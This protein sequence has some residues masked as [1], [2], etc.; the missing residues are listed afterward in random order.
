[1]ATIMLNH[2]LS[3]HLATNQSIPSSI[4]YISSTLET[5]RLIARTELEEGTNGPTLHRWQLRLISLLAASNPSSIR[6]A[7]F[8]LL[9]HTFTSSSTLFLAASKQTLTSAQQVLSTPISKL[10]PTLYLAAVETTKLIVAKSTWYPEWAR[11]NVGAQAVQ[12]FVSSL[13]QAVNESTSLQIKLASLST[14]C[15]L[16]PLFPTALRPLSPSLHAL[17]LSLLCDVT[18]PPSLQDSASNL[19]VSL[20]L[21]APK[22]KEGLREAWKTGVEALVASCDELVSIVT[23]GIFSED[24]L[25][26]HTLSPLALPPLEGDGQSPFPALARLETLSLVLLKALRTPSTEKAGEVSIPVGALVELGVRMVGFNR[27]SPTKERVDPTVHTLTMSLVPKIQVLGCQ[28]LAQLGLCVGTKMVGFSNVV[29][30]TIAR[31]LSTYEVRSP[32]R[33]ALSTT[34]SLLAN[35]LSSHLDPNEASKSLSR[36]WRSLLEDISSVALEPLNVN[37]AST[38]KTAAG[39]GAGRQE[40]R[41]NKRV[42]TSFDPTESMVDTRAAVDK[43]D[44]EITI[45]GLE[46]LERL[47]RAPIS[48]FLPPALQLATSRLLLYISLSP[49]FSTIAPLSTSLQSSTFYPAS[50]TSSNSSPLEI[51]KHSL[52]FK[53]SVLRALQTSVSF[54]IGGVGLEERSLSVWKTC[55]LSSNE[56]IQLIGLRGLNELGKLGHP[57]L[58]IAMENENLA[59]LR[60]DRKGGEVGG[61][62]EEELREGVEEFRRR[63]VEVGEY[64]EE[65]SEEEDQEM[66]EQETRE[67]KKPTTTRKETV[68]TSFAS[69]STANGFNV[70]SSTTTSTASANGGGGG[71]N[72]FASFQAPAFGST[73]VSAP[74]PSTP[75]AV[76]PE[77][78]E[79]PTPA[80]VLSFSTETFTSK[81]KP[82][83]TPKVATASKATREGED[84][85]SD[86]DM[87]PA[88]DMGS[89]GE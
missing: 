67:R 44:L 41:K 56:Q 15:T 80:P 55:S 24:A 74:V 11:E 87:M 23:G 70:S 35:S 45:K 21:L 10:D 88:I 26:N 18:S 36:V 85:D 33:P 72:G 83:V 30:G 31:T 42:K 57:K 46:T 12:K 62:G 86:D 22:G 16:L 1:M 60:R 69:T 54:G 6:S 89:D 43:R 59:R 25:T 51:V 77:T 82:A 65:E 79:A 39:K 76:E 61:E 40:G 28:L 50:T 75:S 2:L 7:G 48:Q 63:D 71:G 17:S 20:Y 52:P 9:H 13:V 37:V 78:K 29:L 8:Q 49:S 81:S 38:E 47:L 27:E 84:S 68:S 58:P 73:I 34:Y 4:N 32:M 5:Q 53:V 19:F 14:I 3:H 66:E 64:R